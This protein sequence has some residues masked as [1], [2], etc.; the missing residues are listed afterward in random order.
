MNTTEDNSSFRQRE[1]TRT[2]AQ[3]AQ[4]LLQHGAESTLIVQMAQRLGFALGIDSVECAL[5]PNAVIITTLYDHNCIT[6]V[7]K[8]L[9]KGINMQVVTEVQ[10]LVIM[11]EKGLYDLQQ[12][13]KK[14]DGI[15]PLKYNRFVVVTMIGL[16][17]ACFAHLSGGDIIVFL[18]TFIASSI[19]MLI[20]Q[21]LTLRHYN[22]LIVFAI[23]AFVASM[24]AGLAV[25]YELGNDPQIALASSVLLLV[26]GFPLINSLA[27]ILK[28]HI[29]MGIAR[30]TLAT[31]LTFGTCLGIV[32]ALSFL[33]IAD[34]G[35]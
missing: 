11:A 12:I 7:R 18:I 30:W 32:F 23:T 16:S 13:R 19:A 10:R 35:R 26:P 28:G 20:R 17:C 6:T 34:W 5:T 31:V 8:N 15:K 14:L 27:D 22:P 24:V 4:M 25:K 2:C 29:N 3:V 9:D 1:I 21:T 33:H